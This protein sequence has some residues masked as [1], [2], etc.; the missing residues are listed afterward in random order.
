MAV[1][2]AE[3]RGAYLHFSTRVAERIGPDFSAPLLWTTAI[4]CITTGCS[5]FAFCT[6]LSRKGRRLWLTSIDGRPVFVVFDHRDNIPITVITDATGHVRAD[7]RKGTV[8]L[9]R[10]LHG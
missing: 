3:F 2:A 9:R 5:S 8:A 4:A 7:R 1:V 10:F 6:R